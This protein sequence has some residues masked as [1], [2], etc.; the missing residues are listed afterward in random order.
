[1]KTVQPFRL[2]VV[3]AAVF[4]GALNV[5]VADD[6]TLS[7]S[8]LN[9]LKKQ[10]PNYAAVKLPLAVEGRLGVVSRNA[11]WLKRISMAFVPA[12]GKQLPKLPDG[13]R[14]VHITGH[15][16]RRKGK[17]VLV[18]HSVRP[19]PSDEKA[20]LAKQ[21]KLPAEDPNAWYKL[22]EWAFSRAVFY[23]DQ[24]LKERARKLMVTGVE[25]ER[26]R[27]K[28]GDA[29]GRLQLA[30]KVGELKL[31]ADVQQ[32]LIHEA[33]HLRW[34]SH[35]A[36]GNPDYL[37]LVAGM[38]SDLP[39]FDER[40]KSVPRDLRAAYQRAPL[41]TYRKSDEQMRRTLNRLLYLEVAL[42]RIEGDAHADGSNGSAIAGRIDKEAPE[43][44]ALAESYR[45][46]ELQYR[47]SR[48]GRL[49]RN[50]ALELVELVK[51]RRSDDASKTVMKKW[52]AAREAQ[53][54]NG[55]ARDLVQLADD[56]ELFLK[57][58]SSAI[59]SLKAA[60]ARNPDF[61]GIEK[62]MADFNLVLDDGKWVAKKAAAKKP[63]DPL[64]QAIRN[65]RVL[66]GMQP[67]QVRR[68]MASAP[69]SIVR[70]A[71]RRK[72]NEVW[73]FR[74]PNNQRMAVH[75]ERLRN[76]S[77]RESKVVAVSSPR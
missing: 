6:E 55:L 41:Q 3:L 48:I 38:K 8:E 29:A 71:G 69:A 13:T 37:T 42:H 26:L 2:L 23:N 18:V 19:A 28:P 5:A 33:H 1:M 75:F 21:L 73:I 51:K 61:P 12:D 60:Y 15:L 40:L 11:L 22:A 74:L 65:G 63:V 4:C 77:R 27:L 67:A 7:V 57:D 24:G 43:L 44:H 35:V 46:K 59:A 49:K 52:L 31:S 72:I 45:E 16:A 53:H 70:V 17:W 64:E 34:R 39:G 62:R 54:K 66:K 36:T 32:E 25:L 68:A 56:Y 58:R 14:N 50:D 20:L 9:A 76:Q 30:K 10:W 47:I